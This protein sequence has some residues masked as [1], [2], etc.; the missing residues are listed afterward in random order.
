[1]V[2]GIV[3][4]IAVAGMIVGSLRPGSPSVRRGGPRAGLSR[5]RAV[6]AVIGAI[7]LPLV[8]ALMS[9]PVGVFLA[10]WLRT[11]DAPRAWASTRATLT[12]VAQGGAVQFGAGVAA[13]AVW[14]VAAWRW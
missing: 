14:G 10:E 3:A 4:A 1:L 13:V 12:G 6:G 7:V 9:W 11:R 8:G 5:R 2:C